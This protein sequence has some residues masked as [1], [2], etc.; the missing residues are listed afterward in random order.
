[1]PLWGTC[2]G[3]QLLSVLVGGYGVLEY[4]AFDAEDLS[5]PLDF[6]AAA[7]TSKLFG[8]GA[9]LGLFAENVTSN[10]HH[11]GV[12]PET[13]DT[14]GALRGFYSVLSTN[15]D[16]KGK[17][18]ASTIEAKEYPIWGVQWPTGV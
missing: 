15:V 16:R 18:F 8:G 7:K 4:E 6:T 2:M 5:L 14:N 17:P 11:D 9:P 1:M 3:L 13:Y 12:D 10:L